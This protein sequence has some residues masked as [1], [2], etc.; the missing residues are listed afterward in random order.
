MADTS[1]DG[2]PT[3]QRW[4]PFRRSEIVGAVLSL[5]L[6]LCVLV[7]LV[8]T[9][10]VVAPLVWVAT[11]ATVVTLAFIGGRRPGTVFRRTTVIVMVLLVVAYLGFVAFM[12][13]GMRDFTF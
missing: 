7:A 5:G 3:R 12:L 9:S 4:E 13:W 2:E 10:P 1:G 8:V 11:A 6:W